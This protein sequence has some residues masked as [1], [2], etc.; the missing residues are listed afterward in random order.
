MYLYEDLS[1][2]D[3]T[4]AIYSADK[5]L[6][7]GWERRGYPNIKLDDIPWHLNNLNERSWNFLIHSWDMIDS[8]FKAY[9]QS[10]NECYLNA[11]IN[12]VKSWIKYIHSTDQ[13]DLSPMTWYDMAV[14]LRAYRLAYLYDVVSHKDLISS[15]DIKLFW[16]VLEQHQEYLSD[17]KNII[18]HNNHGFYQIAGQLAMGR[19][20]ADRSS[21]M[22]QA[23]EQG[24]VRLAAMLNTQ[25]SDDGTH[26]EHSPDYHRMVYETLKAMIDAGLI[27]DNETIEFAKKIEEALSWFVLPDQH[28]VNFGDSDYRLMSRKPVEAARKWQT[29]SM[30]YVVS[31][32]QVG[33]LPKNILQYFPSGGY[34]IVRK[35][36]LI[37]PDVFKSYSYL[38]QIAAFHSRTHKHADDLSFIWSDRGS[39][40]LVDAGRYGYLGKAEQGSDLWLDG[41]W[42]SDPKR[43]YVETT[44]AHNALEFD[45]QNYKRKGAKAYGSALGR[46]VETENGVI[47][48]ETEVKQFSQIRHVRVLIFLPAQWLVVF[49]WFHDNKGDLHDVKQWFHCA[50][51]LPLLPFNSGYMI[52]IVSSMQPLRV[53]PLLDNSIASPIVLAESGDQM[54]GWWSPKERE[55]IPNYAFCYQKN[56]VSTGSFATLFS[57]SNEITNDLVWSKANV[58]GRKIQLRWKD[59][60]GR[61]SLMIERPV[62]GDLVINYNAP[63]NKI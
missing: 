56:Q 45:N 3:R 29:A 48:I 21:I 42:Y 37:R 26:K 34:A 52:P 49:D 6:Q 15:D 44:R 23:Y 63:T 17:D 58:S 22:A 41:Y 19:R 7:D 14:G 54:Q 51:E 1:N 27:N 25:F 57:F 53:I 62:E 12:V 43:V 40:I 47:G 11:C 10:R 32:G 55:L 5:S 50:P 46:T 13:D 20:F 24:Q 36:D 33:D 59:E 35:P 39:N 18:F 2:V 16:E 31:N 60:K 38:S 28:I 61:H 4:K 8:Q 9:E 30:Q